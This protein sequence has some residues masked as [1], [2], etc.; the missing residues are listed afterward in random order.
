MAGSIGAV[1]GARF[2][3]RVR[4]G[5]R[6]APRDALIADITP[7]AIRGAAFGVRQALDTVGAFA[8]PLLAIGLMIVYASDFRAVF[9]WAV[10][11]AVIAMLLMIFGV[12][13]PTGGKPSGKRGWPI[14]GDAI[15][16]AG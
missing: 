2:V 6:S 16:R 14:R 11:P 5:I 13:E 15:E 1:L 10:L 3:D 12:Q 4:K 9:W 8:G 7:P